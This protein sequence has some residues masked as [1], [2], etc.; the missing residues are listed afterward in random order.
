VAGGSTQLHGVASDIILPSLSDLPEFGEGALKNALP[1]DEVPK[2]KYTKWSDTHS[3]FIDQLRRRS[4]ERAKN[5][6]EFHYVM[7]DMD[8]LRHKIDEN[9]ISLNEDVRKKE[10]ADDKLRKETRSKERLARNQEE[11]RIYRVTLDTVDKPNL[12]LVMYP[13]KLAEA[14]KNAVAPKVDPEAAPDADS[15]LISGAGSDSDNK[16]P[17]IDPE[18]D[19]ALNILADLADFSRGPKTASANH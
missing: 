6:P 17:A 8:R 2:A 19:E 14:K 15:D 5:D 3:L 9:R 12:Q 10:L 4:E 13:G 16:E 18:R 7:E 1:Y 11:P